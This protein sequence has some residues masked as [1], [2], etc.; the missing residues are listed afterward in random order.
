MVINIA[1]TPYSS[2]VRYLDKIGSMVKGIIA[3]EKF[4]ITYINDDLN[5]F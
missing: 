1:I 5:K 4:E 3:I 2:G